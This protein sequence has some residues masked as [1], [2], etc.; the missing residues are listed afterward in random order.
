MKMSEEM[1]TNNT[2]SRKRVQADMVQYERLTVKNLGDFCIVSVNDMKALDAQ[3]VEIQTL[4]EGNAHLQQQTMQVIESEKN[5]LLKVERLQKNMT[6]VERENLQF[7]QRIEEL[8]R[9]NRRLAESYKALNIEYGK[10][11]VFKE[12]AGRGR[13]HVLTPQQVGLIRAQALEGWSVRQSHESLLDDGVEVSYETVRKVVADM[14]AKQKEFDFELEDEV[15]EL[16][17][18]KTAQNAPQSFLGGV[19]VGKQSNIFGTS[20]GDS[21]ANGSTEQ[22]LERFNMP[23]IS[24]DFRKRD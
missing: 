22:Q 19:E 11:K 2:I 3:T 9:E 24:A 4:R 18:P 14:N 6:V 12:N 10:L 16:D 17:M 23:T 7:A 13:Q 5:A 15:I 21:K 20:T 8:E 1:Q